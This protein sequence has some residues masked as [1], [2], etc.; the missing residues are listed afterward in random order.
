MET[1]RKNLYVVLVEPKNP[2]NIGSAARAMKNMGIA[3]LRLVKPADYR[4]VDEQRK[5]GY[6]SQEI[7][8][9]SREFDSL[10]EALADISLIF[11]ATSRKGK[12]KRDFVTPTEAAD[13]ISQRLSKEKIALVFGREDFGVTI[14]ES[15]L[16][17][18]YISIPAAVQ[19]PSLNLSQAVMVVAYE[20]FKTVGSGPQPDSFPRMAPRKSFERLVDNIWSLMKSLEIREEEKGLFHR[21]LKRAINRS[22][23]T[24]ADIAVFD[25][26]CKQVRWFGESYCN[27]KF[28]VKN[29]S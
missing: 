7:I 24:N 10:P 27:R 6:R 20:I 18:Y 9:N 29:D 19:Y 8:E 14:D 17:N 11:L 22:R 3:N 15:Q 2:G 13:I 4:D 16:A 25:R 23:W 21:S 28:E 5:M 1:Y 26:L 12:W